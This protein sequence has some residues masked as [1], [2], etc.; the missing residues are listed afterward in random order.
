MRAERDLHVRLVEGLRSADALNFA[1]RRRLRHVQHVVDR[2]DPDEHAGG[3]GDR[4]RDAVVL[5]EHGDGLFLI[6]AGLQRD[7]API[8]QFRDEVLDRRQQE[9]ANADVVDQ[10]DPARRRRR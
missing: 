3:V 1:R 8:H 9:L 5:P 10:A 6:V 7:E 4:Q 2:D